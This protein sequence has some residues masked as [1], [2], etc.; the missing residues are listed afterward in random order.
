MPLL[1][2]IKNV[3]R[4]AFSVLWGAD[5]AV[6]NSAGVDVEAGDVAGGVDADGGGALARGGACAGSVETGDGSGGGALEA[7]QDDAGVDVESGDDSGSID[8]EAA[9]A[10]IGDAVSWDQE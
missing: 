8:A 6:E 7:V 5:V 1:T 10:L 4:D 3:E 2:C 9:G